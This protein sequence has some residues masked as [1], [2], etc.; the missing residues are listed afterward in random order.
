VVRVS[1]N[2]ANLSKDVANLTRDLPVRL[3]R[4]R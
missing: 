2:V 1:P 3:Q 4:V